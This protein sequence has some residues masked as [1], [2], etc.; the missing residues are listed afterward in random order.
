MPRFGPTTHAT[1]HPGP[2]RRPK[3]NGSAAFCKIGRNCC[4][5]V[6]SVAVSFSSD[7]PTHVGADEC[8][9]LLWHCI[10]AM[11]G[12]S[13]F[14]LWLRATGKVGSNVGPHLAAPIR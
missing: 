8:V 9:V 4:V 14:L 10:G 12:I 11:E 1:A 13:L 6:C 3:R 7:P 5:S 2:S